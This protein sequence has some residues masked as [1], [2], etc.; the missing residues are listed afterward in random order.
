[1]AINADLQ[2]I[3]WRVPLASKELTKRGVPKTERPMPVDRF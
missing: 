1:M 2:K 3:L